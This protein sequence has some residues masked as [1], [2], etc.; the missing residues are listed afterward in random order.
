M[1]YYFSIL[2]AK[3]IMVE[4][5]QDIFRKPDTESTCIDN[6]SFK[7]ISRRERQRIWEK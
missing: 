3:Y 4:I 5:F 7:Q 6:N 2:L 1:C